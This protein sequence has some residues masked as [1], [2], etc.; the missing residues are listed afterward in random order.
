MDGR[1]Q[2]DETLHFLSATLGSHMVLQRAPQTAIVWG[3]TSPGATVTTTMQASNVEHC[4]TQPALVES[5]A[6]Q[7]LNLT[8]VASSDGTWRQTLPATAAS[9]VPFQFQFSSSS[10]AKE[11]ATMQ[12]VLFGD[13]YI[14]GG[15]SNMEYAMPAVTNTSAEKQIANQFPTIRFFSVGHR[16]QSTTPLRDLQTFWEPWQVASNTTIDKDFS[17]YSHLFSTFSAVCWFFGRE[18]SSQLSATGEV[19]IGLI[20]NNWGGT[21]L[22]QWAPRSVLDSCNATDPYP[23]GGPMFNAMISPYAEGPMAI[24]GVT[25]YQGEADTA[26]S[27]SADQ[28]SC[29]F[30]KMISA[31]RDALHAPNAYF[32]FV[33]LST[34]CAQPPQSLPQMRQAQ[35]SALE[36]PNVGYATNVDHGNGCNIHPGPKQYIGARL[37]L[38]ALSLNYGRSVSWKSPTY[39]SAQQLNQQSGSNTVSLLVR[40]KDVSALGLETVYPFNY[41]QPSGGDNAPPSVVDC[42]ATYPVS[43][44]VNGSMATQCAWGSLSVEGSGWLNATTTVQ[45]GGQSILL[46]ATLPNQATLPHNA[47]ARVAG[48][49]YG[50]GP[51]PML[52][53]YDKSTKLPVLPWNESVGYW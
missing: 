16:T 46:T 2:D 51:I 20:S 33:Q 11:N 43:P 31:W 49:A 37:A 15:Q 4:K 39:S 17:R 44:T 21:K 18:L 48:S 1:S 12:D 28:Y 5:S 40:L 8:T 25:W 38:S 23:D 41:V 53:V 30:P 50:W 45:P 14:C 35:M 7:Q 29:T 36:L 13:V 22:E 32:G 47:V 6:C 10:V 34:W 42:T 27:A 52:S 3:F 19:P 24:S 26:S 9:R